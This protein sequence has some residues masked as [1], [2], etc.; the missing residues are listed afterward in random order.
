MAELQLKEVQDFLSEE[1]QVLKKDFSKVREADQ[2]TFDSKV[3][4]AMD[5]LA[6]DIQAKHAEVQ[7]DFDK[8]LAEINEKSKAQLPTQR[9]NFGW[10]LAET[11]KD[12]H[13]DM[14]KNIKAGR[15]M[16]MNMKA[17]DY[18]DFTGYEPFVTDFRDPILNKYES[19][20]YRNILPSGTMGG[21]FVK[22][23]KETTQVGGADT[24]AYGD[25]AK[26][27]IEPKMT[28][29]QADA[30]WIAGLIKEV[31]ISMIEDLSWMTSFLSQKG[32]NEVLKKEDTWI[33]GILTDAGNSEAYDGS[34]TNIVD[35]LIDAAFR[36]L[37]DNLHNP[38]GIVISNADY[39]NILL[40][41]AST[42]G[43]YDLPA[44][45]TVNPTT[46]LLQ[47]VGLPVYAH[48]YFSQGEGLVGDWMEAQLLTRSAPR[49]RFFDQNSDNAEKNVILVRIEERVALPVFYDNAFITVTLPS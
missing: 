1:L 12:S 41:K 49:I 23:P 19:F 15:G 36:Q 14:V 40:N 33:Q 42:S 6:S 7:K 31:P 10:S 30:T 29:Y 25:G 38:N 8:A 44:V 24:W 26:P 17:F 27:E 48:S 37:K 18:N 46:G 32:R 2:T 9:K 21:E 45:S 43:E 20:H 3:K 5:K 4:D 13:S 47:L 16:E 34:K 11:L 22:Y 39:V 35:I 28:T